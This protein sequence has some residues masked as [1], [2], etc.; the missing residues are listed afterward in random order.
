MAYVDTG[1]G[2]VVILYLLIWIGIGGGVGAAIGS[3][4]G[5]SA[6]GFFLGLFLGIIG[7]IIVAV[8]EPTAEQRL[9]RTSELARFI[10][11]PQNNQQQARVVAERA[12]PWCAELIKPAAIVCRFCNRD[13]T[14]DESMVS[15]SSQPQYQN[16]TTQFVNAPVSYGPGNKNIKKLLASFVLV[17]S[18]QRFLISPAITFFRFENIRYVADAYLGPIYSEGFHFYD[19]VG[20]LAWINSFVWFIFSYSALAL[21]VYVLVNWKN[22]E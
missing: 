17:Y 18:V 4:K 19:F 3:S 8:M 9:L 7:W 6:A 10:Q 2:S 20:T 14:P 21:S 15:Y 11:Q 13:V 22:L 16:E 5:R 1:T 12:C